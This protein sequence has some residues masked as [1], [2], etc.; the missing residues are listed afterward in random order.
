MPKHK[1]RCK[2]DGHEYVIE[3]GDFVYLWQLQQVYHPGLG[4]LL[5]AYGRLVK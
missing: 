5:C 4:R 2:A 3:Y 1:W